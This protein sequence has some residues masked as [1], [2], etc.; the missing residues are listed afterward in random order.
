MV[1]QPAGASKQVDVTPSL[2]WQSKTQMPTP[3]GR[4]AQ[5]VVDGR[6]YVIGGLSEEGWTADVEAYDTTEDLWERRASKPVAVANVGAAV[7]EGLVYVPG[8]LMEGNQLT[9]RL[10][11]YDPA[12]DRW[13]GAAPL[14]RP[15]CAYAIAPYEEGFYLFGG[16]DGE[17]YVATVYYYDAASDTLARGNAPAHRARLCRRGDR[18]RRHLPDRRVRRQHRV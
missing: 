16:W 8:G 17:H 1:D 4:F 7:V 14:P 13:S 6:I 2:R 3:R 9:D 18:G 15:L 5:A 11:V 10:E 12:D